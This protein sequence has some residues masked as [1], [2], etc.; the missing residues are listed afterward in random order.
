ML[1]ERLNIFRSQIHQNVNPAFV[2]QRVSKFI[3]SKEDF[4]YSN[5]TYLPFSFSNR[6]FSPLI[7]Y[8]LLASID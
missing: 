3:Y 5:T 7:A 4:Y 6:K 2:Q 8:I 1:T